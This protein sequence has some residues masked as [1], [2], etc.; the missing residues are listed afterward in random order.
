MQ[1]GRQATKSTPSTQRYLNIA[2]IKEGTVVL[3]DGTLR[4][5]LLASSINFSL[6]SEDEQNAIIA[7]YINFINTL[8]FPVQIVIQ[9]RRLDMD[10]YLLNLNQ[11]ER[12]QTNELLRLQI[13]D[14]RQYVGELVQI[15]DIMSK[16]FYVVV[17]Y[18]PMSDKQKS[19]WT[20]LR[21][22]FSAANLVKLSQQKFEKR[23]GK[24]ERRVSNVASA[25]GSMGIKSARLDTQGLI[26]LY[27]RTYNPVVSEH[28]K[29]ADLNKLKVEG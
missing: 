11:I 19:W 24:L 1:K 23:R 28:E 15:G 5:V 26:E 6:K 17:P 22:V 21:E 29:L 20:R 4:A 25:L 14:Y 7:A 13:A 8:E 18:N 16:K 12:E 3:K 27:Y 2:E 10:G 9:S